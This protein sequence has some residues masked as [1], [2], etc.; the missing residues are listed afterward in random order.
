MALRRTLLRAFLLAPLAAP[1]GYWAGLL[2]WGAV[3]AARIGDQS[4]PSL[5]S[6]VGLLGW[7]LAVGAPIAY[8]AALV[9]GLPI[10]LGLRRA[11]LL[12]RVT[13]WGGGAIIG[14]SVALLMAPNLGRELFRIPFQPWAGAALGVV[15]A[16]VFWRL[17][18]RPGA[19]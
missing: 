15:V 12:N 8:G 13:L 3:R 9:G 17:H 11:G 10:Y 1:V 19:A 7:V 4:T 5:S 2:L 16:E 14:I 6:V 18:P